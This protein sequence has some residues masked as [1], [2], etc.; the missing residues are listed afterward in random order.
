MKTVYTHT[1]F[2]VRNPQPIQV[3][4]LTSESGKMRLTI[5]LDELADYENRTFDHAG[6]LDDIYPVSIPDDHFGAILRDLAIDSI[7]E[8][9]NLQEEYL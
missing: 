7:L 5:T 8:E 6:A 4:T 2:G 1:T 9:S 3:I